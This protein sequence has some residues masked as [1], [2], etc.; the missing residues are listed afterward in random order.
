M[1]MNAL[2]QLTAKEAAEELHISEYLL[3]QYLRKGVFKRAF[4]FGGR[5]ILD[6]EEVDKFKAGKIKATGCF[7]KKT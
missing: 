6:R 5:W 2:F 3:R 1:N 7:S 4:K